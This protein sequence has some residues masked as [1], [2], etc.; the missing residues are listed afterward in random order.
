LISD[1]YK[2]ITIQYNHLNLPEK[3]TK[4][5]E[6]I[7][8]LY[9]ATGTK[10]QKKTTA[11]A[12]A[13]V[14]N[15]TLAIND[16][17]IP[18]KLYQATTITSVGKVAANS[19]VTFTAA[20]SIEL[21]TGFEATP[22]FFAN[23]DATPI[24]P[25]PTTTTQDYT[26]G[27]DYK[28]NVLEAMYHAE[29]RAYRSGTTWQYEYTLKDHLGNSRVTFADLDN[30]GAI[31]PLAEILQENHYYPFGLNQE[32]KWLNNAAL[33]D[34]KYQYNGKELNEDLGLNWNDYG[35]R[36]YDAAIGRWNAIDPLAMTTPTWSPYNYVH[37]TPSNAIDPDG[38]SCVGCGKNGE[39]INPPEVSGVPMYIGSNAGVLTDFLN[40]Q[41]GQTLH[42]EDGI[43]QIALVNNEQFNQVQNLAFSESWNK[44]Q[45]EQYDNLANGNVLNLSSDIGLLTRLAFTEFTNNG[46]DA[47]MIAVE[48]VLNRVAYNQSEGAYAKYSPDLKAATSVENAILAPGGYA[49]T[50]SKFS[51]KN[52]YAYVK[53]TENDNLK[54]ARSSL[55]QAAY[56][57]Y[58]VTNDPVSR[59]GTMYYHSIMDIKADSKH[60]YLNWKSYK[61]GDLQ[62]LNLNIK[63]ISQAAKFKK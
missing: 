17:P 11:T 56:A 5:S 55:L 54:G 49:Q 2:G 34:T 4:G 9:D 33:P 52:P 37:N 26:G 3:V 45:S 48:S 43:D 60:N 44:E 14:T 19:N 41:T 61:L 10:L 15:A 59:T 29:G 58:K 28:N 24:A 46:L 8:W 51:F 21:N 18:S 25:T 12:A 20:Q 30:N 16:N 40:T 32:G 1:T 42:V 6:T 36:W 39:N 62:L 23:I 50:P 35:A 63:G 13:S 53:Q 22:T 38:R 27:I 47:K 7:S 57:A 31:N